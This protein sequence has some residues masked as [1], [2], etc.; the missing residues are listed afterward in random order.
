MFDPIAVLNLDY[1]F[2]ALDESLHIDLDSL[3]AELQTGRVCVVVLIHFFGFVDPSFAE[4]VKIARD[5]DVFIVEDE[6]HAMLTD[7]VGGI[8]GRLGDAC[9]LFVPQNASS[10]VRW[11]R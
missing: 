9:I 2:Y 5:H 4:A 8:C 7:L 1:S 11:C 10:R 6:A 3:R